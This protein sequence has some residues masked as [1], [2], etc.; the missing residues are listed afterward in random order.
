MKTSI[1]RKS[2]LQ[3]VPTDVGI[4]AIKIKEPVSIVIF[5]ASGDL[6]KRKLMP[7]LYHLYQDGYLPEQISIIGVSRSPMTDEAFRNLIQTSMKDA[8]I[9]A[10]ATHPI[11]QNMFYI[12]GNVD[13]AAAFKKILAKLEDLEKQRKQ[14]CGNRL[15]YLSVAPD[16][17]SVIVKNLSENKL[18]YPRS[19]TEA[20]SRVIIEKP[21]GTDL[22]SACK[23]NDSVKSFL[24]ESQI[25]RIDHYLGKETVQNI[26]SFRFGNSIFDPLLNNKYVDSVQVTVAEPLGMEGKR[27]A[28]YDTAGAMRDMMQNH[29]MQVVALTAMEPPS[30]LDAQSIRDEKVKVLRSLVPFTAAEVDAYTV[31][32]QYA[33]GELDGKPVKGYL[34]EEGVKPDSMTESYTAIKLRIDNWRWAGVPFYM[35]HGKRLKKKVTEVAIY[36]KDPPLNLFHQAAGN[37]DLCMIADRPKS[38]VLVFRIQPHEGLRL[39]V[40]CKQPGLRVQLEEVDMDFN[41]EKGFA[42]RVPE[43]YERLILD[44]L[45]GDQSLYTRSDEV[46]YQWRFFDAILKGWAASGQKK[47]PQYTPFTDGPEDARRL[48]SGGRHSWRA[49]KDM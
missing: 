42:Q 5:G 44:S 12:A 19:Q 16:F 36:F 24:S 39:S 22:A 2:D 33:A 1:L 43:A 45:R 34:Q 9:D 28:Y 37:A 31:R 10:P 14:A 3:S 26:L 30:A 13:D 11:L 4:D 49:I 6:N 21:F 48:V 15:F 35:R 18:T 17:F 40:A 25:Y 8:K 23:L 32:A 7:A 20:W 38:N 47:L 41:Y 46:D 27:G 29:M